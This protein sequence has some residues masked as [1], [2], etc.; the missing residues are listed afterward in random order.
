MDLIHRG[1]GY[2]IRRAKPDD[3][4]ALC[5][6]VRKVH[7]RGALDITQERDPDF[8]AL[9]RMHLADDTVWVVENDDHQIGACG[10]IVVR[11]AWIDGRIAR[12]GYLSDLRAI[13]GHRAARALA[14]GYGQVMGHVAE[15][16]GAERFYTVIFDS[17]ELAKQA[18]VQR[19]KKVRK[20]QPIYQVMTPFAMTSVQFTRRKPKPSR[21]IRRATSAD[22]DALVTFLAAQ[23]K[24]RTMGYVFDQ[25]MLEA[26]FEHWPDFS[27]ESFLL[28]LDDGGRIVGTLAPWNTHPFKR[29]RVLGYHGHMWW[30]K[31]VFDLGA[32]VLRYPPLPKAGDCFDF[33][34][35]SH[36]EIVD[37][38]PAVLRDLLLAAY[39]ELDGTGLH[40][41]SAMIPR[42]SPLQAAFSG[43]TVNRTDMTIYAVSMPG[44]EKR[45]SWETMHPGF[46]M[47]LS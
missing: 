39:A 26:R 2:S 23:S 16:L 35:L 5:D 21:T 1:P 17:N 46:E 43:F 31:T 15:T 20:N 47:A 28:A 29:T 36:L 13:P 44:A 40:F 14:A 6:V 27:I 3:S 38:D 22:L 33:V 45:D 11:D 10:T 37:D 9:P 8:F 34:F 12:V 42:G 25:A 19:K 32:A 41:M 7:L 24:R 18:L 4:Q 30:V